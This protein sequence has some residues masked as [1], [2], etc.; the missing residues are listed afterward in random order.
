ML[1]ARDTSQ[2][3]Q[4]VETHQWLGLKNCGLF[5]VL[6]CTMLE[7]VIVWSQESYINEEML[8]KN[9]LFRRMR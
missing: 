5:G 6:K 8:I 7:P 9:Q 4:V 2:F 3:C 1:A